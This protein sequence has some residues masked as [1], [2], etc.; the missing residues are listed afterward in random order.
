MQTVYLSQVLV[1]ILHCPFCGQE[2]MDEE[3]AP[4]LNPCL[5][6]LFLGT[7]EGFEYAS[8]RFVDTWSD[9]L[10]GGF[11]ES[12]IHTPMRELQIADSICFALESVPPS[13][14][15]A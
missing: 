9:F 6:T 14:L 8:D 15:C 13:M 3:K 5:H 11:R 4:D 12:D 10:D 2:V 7:D 1:S